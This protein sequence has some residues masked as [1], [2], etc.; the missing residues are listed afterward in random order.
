LIIENKIE[1]IFGRN[2]SFAGYIFLFTGVGIIILKFFVLGILI[3]VISL[4]V[5][6]SFSGVEVDTVKREIRQFDKIF[7]LIKTG[8]WR[9]LDM[10]RGLTLIPFTKTESV[11]SRSNRITSLTETD[12]RIF[13]VNKLSRPEMAIKRCKTKEEAGRSIDEFSI[14]LHLPVFTIKR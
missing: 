14:W 6:F 13:L 3:S 4:F 2:A 7:G 11:A 1:K 9:S 12:Y 5:I 8:K 10:Y